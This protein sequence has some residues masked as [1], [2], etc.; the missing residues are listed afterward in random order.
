MLLDRLL[1]QGGPFSPL[2]LPGLVAWYLDRSM[3]MQ[4]KH[5]LAIIAPYAGA[6]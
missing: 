4:L 1:L 2:A 6:P 3:T 5:W